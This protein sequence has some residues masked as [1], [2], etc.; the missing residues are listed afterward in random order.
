MA[1]VAK[2]SHS[3]TTPLGIYVHIPFCQR[4]CSYC[5]FATFVPLES[6]RKSLLHC[7]ERE[8]LTHPSSVC[9]TLF[10]GGGTPSFIT[11]KEFKSLI[12]ALRSRFD[13]GAGAE[14]TLEANPESAVPEKI[15]CW[16]AE[17]LNRLSLGVQSTH[18]RLLE[19]L[20]RLHTWV[21]AKNAYSQARSQGFS[22]INLDLMYGLPGQTMEDWRATLEEVLALEPEHLSAYALTVEEGTPFFLQGVQVSDDLSADMYETAAECLT[23]AGYEHYEISNFARPGFSCRHNLKYWRNEPTLGLGPSAAS[24]DGEWRWENTDDYSVYENRLNA[25][26]PPIESR[27]TLPLEQRWGEQLMLGLRLAE[28]VEP[29]PDAQKLFG[30]VLDQFTTL[31]FLRRLNGRYIPTLKGWRLSNQLFMELLTPRTSL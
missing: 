23:A 11:R 18:P 20:G 24:F 25:G 1:A 9:E 6:Q 21:S 16:L 14:L 30:P 5:D 10:F 15:D 8:V 4:R 26:L 12:R 2:E 31:E 22:N 7:L 27:T 19:R 17:G 28:G 13:I 3:L 29:T